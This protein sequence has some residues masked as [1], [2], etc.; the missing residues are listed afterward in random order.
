ME[1]YTEMLREYL[2][3][4]RDVDK[5]VFKLA[6]RIYRGINSGRF[7]LDEALAILNRRF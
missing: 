1:G 4:R 5:T 2:R 7:T 6:G 3:E